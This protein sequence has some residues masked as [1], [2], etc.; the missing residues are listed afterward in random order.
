[1]GLCLVERTP[2]LEAWLEEGVYESWACE[3]VPHP[4]RGVSAHGVNRVCSNDL[5]ASF[6]GTPGDERPPGTAS[7]KELYD[8][9]ANLVGY[10][11]AVKLDAASAAGKGWYWYERAAD[12]VNADGR[13]DASQAKSACVGCHS[14]AGT[15]GTHSV[16]GSSDYVYLQVSR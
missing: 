2:A 7:V 6:T 10:A 1:M 8:D 15:D 12:R 9:A 14:A 11:V 13:G 4:R 3:T 5:A 16:T